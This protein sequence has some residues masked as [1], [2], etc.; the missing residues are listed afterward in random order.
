MIEVNQTYDLAPG[1]DQQ[2]YGQLVAKAIDILRKAPGFVELRAHRNLLGSP[3]VRTT[4][5]WQSVADWG[6]FREGTEQQAMEAELRAFVTNFKAE[7]WGPSPLLPEP[8][9]ASR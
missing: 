9:R 6:K 5:V 8:L 3:Q 1:I 4:T 7:L 2:A